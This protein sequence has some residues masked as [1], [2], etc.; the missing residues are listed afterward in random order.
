MIGMRERTAN[1]FA[2]RGSTHSGSR[3][4]TLLG[5]MVVALAAT[6]LVPAGARPADRTAPQEKME[7]K[8]AAAQNAAAGTVKVT[9]W[10]TFSGQMMGST[11]DKKD[12]GTP[13]TAA[14]EQA[15]AE[16]IGSDFIYRPENEDFFWRFE[17]TKIPVIAGGLGGV[18]IVGVPSTIYV[19]PLNAK[20]ISYQIRAASLGTPNITDPTNA[21]V[22]ASFALFRC[23]TEDLCLEVA[24]LKGGYG[25][26][27]E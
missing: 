16:S 3:R 23:D 22:G 2:G 1:G 17:V 6:A 5:L 25:T 12:D 21:S 26:T 19:L 24:R 9:G 10:A 13:S 4:L 14:A 27:G 7:V 11:D 20:G 15:G 8:R 18:S